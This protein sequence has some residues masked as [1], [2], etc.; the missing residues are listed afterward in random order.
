[1]TQTQS[2]LNTP[3]ATRCRIE[4]NGAVA[5]LARSIERQHPG[6]RFMQLPEADRRE[7]TN[8]VYS[9]MT[10]LEKLDWF[11]ESMFGRETAILAML[12]RKH[13]DLEAVGR[14]FLDGY[15]YSVGWI[16]DRVLY[17]QPVVLKTT[18]LS[19][20]LRDIGAVQLGGV[21]GDGA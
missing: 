8:F 6:D 17:G 9:E 10:D 20:A 4:D 5:E 2:I 16:Y 1:M 13:P 12:H 21:W 19:D 11:G 7:F 15:L 3:L 18:G 14:L